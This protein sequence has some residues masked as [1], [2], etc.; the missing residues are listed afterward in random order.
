MLVWMNERPWVKQV[1]SPALRFHGDLIWL[2]AETYWGFIPTCQCQEAPH[3]SFGGL[4]RNGQS[5]WTKLSFLGQTF[6]SLWPFHNSLEIR[7][8]NLICQIIDF[9]GTCDLCCCCVLW[10]RSQIWIGSRKRLALLG[11]DSSEARWSSSYNSISEVKGYSDW[12]C[13]G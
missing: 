8:T 1:R 13:D 3:V 11:I 5:V 7:S 12:D 2:M 6:Q 10:L 9:Q 4:T